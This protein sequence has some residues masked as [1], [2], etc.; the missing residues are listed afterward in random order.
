MVSKRTNPLSL[1]DFP[2]LVSTYYRKLIIC[3]DSD[4]NK[5]TI[6]STHSVQSVEEPSEIIF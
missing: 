5:S 1:V 6:L 4:L 2:G 3:S